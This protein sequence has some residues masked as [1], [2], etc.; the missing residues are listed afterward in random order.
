MKEIE[1][2]SFDVFDT[3]ITRK[4]ATCTGVFSIIQ[5]Q[6]KDKEFLSDVFRNNFYNLR[7]Q[8]EMLTR[9]MYC[10][11]EIEDITLNQI[12]ETMY[13]VGMINKGDINYLIELEKEIELKNTIGIKENIDLVKKLL[14]DGKSVIAVSDMYLDANTIHEMLCIADKCLSNIKVYVSSETKKTKLSGNMY[15]LVQRKEGI[16]YHEWFHKGDNLLSDVQMASR[17]GINAIH[18]KYVNLNNLEKNIL[19]EKDMQSQLVIGAT[20]NIRLLNQLSY[21][22]NMGNCIG[23]VILYP[24]VEWIIKK[25]I[26]KEIKR[27]YFVA[28]DGYILKKIADII[29]NKCGYNIKTKYIYGSRSAWRIPVINKE[30]FEEVLSLSN[31]SYIKNINNLG[32][33]LGLASSEIFPFIPNE[34]KKNGLLLS[35]GALNRLLN[36]LRENNEFWKYMDQKNRDKKDLAIG[37]LKQEINIDDD[38]FAFVELHG[39]GYTQIC[40]GK[41]IHNFYDKKIENFYYTMDTLPLTNECTFNVFIPGQLSQPLIL[42]A[43]CRA[44]HGQTVGYEKEK[45]KIIPILDDNEIRHLKNY[46]YSE[47]IKGVLLFAQYFENNSVEENVNISYK[48]LKYIAETPDRE[49]INFIAGIPFELT[50]YKKAVEFAPVLTKKQMIDIYVLGNI[51]EKN[52]DGASFSYSEM[53]TAVQGI[54]IDFY[55][56]VGRNFAGRCIRL[57]FK[58]RKRISDRSKSQIRLCYGMEKGSKIVIYGAGNLGNN[59]YTVFKKKKIFDVVLWVDKW[60]EEC[61]KRGLPVENPESIKEVR[62]DYIVIAVVDYQNFTSIKEKLLSLDIHPSKFNW[63]NTFMAE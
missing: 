34:Y 52:Y 45:N 41:L 39:S 51:V 46:Q 49:V 57:P 55:K 8:I 17:F 22:E 35:T 47:Y 50:G 6:I 62:F 36:E 5:N 12:Y 59:L 16:N 30:N 13:L 48:C 60:F 58:W 9:R 18:Y 38:K 63:I 28:R 23:A 2:H 26:H 4:T 25:S 56:N 15:R 10:H 42:E 14:N 31:M 24:Y 53:K 21:K 33:I 61:S 43:L 3:L 1:M 29:I 54:N 11:G 27:L 32:K 20:K 40:L 7:I 37:Y 19:D 44:E